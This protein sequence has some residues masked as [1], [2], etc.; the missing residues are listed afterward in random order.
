M[1]VVVTYCFPV[2]RGRTFFP[3]AARFAETYLKFPGQAEHE[4][5]II[6][7]GGNPTP[8]QMQP[9]GRIPHKLMVHDNTGWDIGAYQ[10]AA[11]KIG[12]D[13][14]VCLG[15]FA[16]FHRAGWLERMVEAWLLEGPGLY[17][18]A[19]YLAPNW[20]VRTTLFWCPPLLLNSYPDYVG[21]SRA[22]R[23]EFEHGNHSFT[24][25]C[26][27]AG[28][29]CVMVTWKGIYPFDTWQDNGPDHET[30]LV[31]DQHLHDPGSRIEAGRFWQ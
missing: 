2:F 10:R 16:H 24:R 8:N 27:Q 21:S 11:E 26:L 7:N 30:I 18:C 19:A 13:L 9:F 12:C 1:K 20:H 4:L 31:R 22:S 3:A 5:V 28:F 14:L 15:S 17:G 29:P 25:H 6:A 23:Y